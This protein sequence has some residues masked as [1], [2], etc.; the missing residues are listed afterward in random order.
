METSS[1]K[2]NDPL[3]QQRET[4]TGAK[5]DAQEYET[6]DTWTTLS[7]KFRRAVLANIVHENGNPRT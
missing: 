4:P 1:E 5:E 6:V 3:S 7:C 2:N